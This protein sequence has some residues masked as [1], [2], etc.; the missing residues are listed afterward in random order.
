MISKEEDLLM[1]FSKEEDLLMSS[2]TIYLWSWKQVTRK[3]LKRL[4]E[5]NCQLL[6]SGTV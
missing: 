5:Q 3:M 4:F 2:G 1:S 6:D